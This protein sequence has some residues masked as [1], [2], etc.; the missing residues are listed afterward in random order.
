MK[1]GER[2]PATGELLFEIDS[3]PLHECVTALGGVPL[4][5]RFMLPGTSRDREDQHQ[6]TL[7]PLTGGL[8]PQALP[9]SL[10]LYSII[11]MARRRIRRQ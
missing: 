9:R 11:V 3:E 6:H 5:V 1:S 7:L 2:S 8:R 4:L 10:Y